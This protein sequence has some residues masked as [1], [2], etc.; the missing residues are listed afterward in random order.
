[1]SAMILSLFPGIDLLG[2]GFE[3]KGFCVVRG[4]DPLFGGDIR[5]FT[6][7]RGG[8][9]GIIGGSPCQDYSKARRTPPTG[10]GDELLGHFHRCVKQAQPEWFLLENVPAAPWLLVEGYTIQRMHIR[11]SEFGAAQHRLRVFQFGYRSGGPLTISRP[12]NKPKATQRAA[13]ASEGSSTNRRGWA[14]FCALQ[15]LEQP[16]RLDH[17]TQAGKYL[18]VGNGVFL[19]LAESIAE[20]IKMRDMWPWQVQACACECGRDTD[21]KRQFATA[22]CRKRAQ[23]RR[24]AERTNSTRYIGDAAPVTVPDHVTA[25]QSPA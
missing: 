5:N 12:F 13:M 3:R 14:E 10:L 24:D 20:E 19:P 16:L 18:A 15:G 11:A 17:F 22:A 6:A 4:P 23:R 2:M 9:E 25:A 1:M 8:F 7:P 21:G